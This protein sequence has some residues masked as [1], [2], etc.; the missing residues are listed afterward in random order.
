MDMSPPLY[1][2][3]MMV[4]SKYDTLFFFAAGWVAYKDYENKF[5]YTKCFQILLLKYFYC[6]IRVLKT[7]SYVTRTQ[8]VFVIVQKRTRFLINGDILC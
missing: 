1:P 6:N 4:T 7:F 8:S 5:N 2:A 3:L